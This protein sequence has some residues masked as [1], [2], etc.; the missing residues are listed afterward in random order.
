LANKC[1]DNN[2]S[3]GLPLKV[4]RPAVLKSFSKKLLPLS[5]KWEYCY[6]RWILR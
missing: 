1:R 3:E 6:W 4:K 2:L 5:S